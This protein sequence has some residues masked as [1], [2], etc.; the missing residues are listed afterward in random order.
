MTMLSFIMTIIQGLLNALGLFRAAQERGAGA[1]ISQN[2]AIN[3]EVDRVNRAADA[4]GRV[5]VGQVDDPNDRD[6]P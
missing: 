2:E 5:P 4:A 3:D 6:R 1:A